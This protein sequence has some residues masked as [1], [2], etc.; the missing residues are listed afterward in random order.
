MNPRS[1]FARI[2]VLIAKKMMENPDLL[3]LDCRHSSDYR[4]EH[5]DGAEPLG[6]YNIERFLL[7]T[8]RQTPVLIYCYHGNSSQVRA[9]TFVDFGFATVYSMDGGYEAWKNHFGQH[10]KSLNEALRCW[11][12]THGFSGEGVDEANGDGVTPLMRAAA[13]GDLETVS[14]LLLAGADPHRCN[15]DGNQALWYACISGNQQILDLLV[16][17]GMD[18]DHQNDNGATCLMYAASAGK[19]G[20]VG[21]LLCLGADRS[22]RSLD[23]FTALDMAANLDCLNLLRETPSRLQGLDQRKL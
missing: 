17:V 13:D 2:D 4:L 3:L 1:D 18:V 23:D 6:D 12:K 7:E 14:G 19:T 20:A 11:L 10:R 21:H 5:I 16:A 15:R 8:P 22:L 9:Q